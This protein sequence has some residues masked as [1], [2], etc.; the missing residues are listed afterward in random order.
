MTER[1]EESKYIKCS[2]CWCKYINDD[3]HIKQDFGYNRLE[4]RY[5]T[6]VKC[7]G[8]SREYKKV[9]IEKRTELCGNY[10]QSILD[11]HQ[12]CSRCYKIKAKTAYEESNHR[13]SSDGGKIYE[14]YKTCKACRDGDKRRAVRNKEVNEK[15]KWNKK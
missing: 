3:E 2:K 11:H 6:C 5:K 9:Y 7:R 14:W 4:K 8:R 15:E 1:S 12:Y 13:T 10:G